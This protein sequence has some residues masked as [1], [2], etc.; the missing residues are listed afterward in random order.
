MKKFNFKDISV[1]DYQNLVKIFHEES[2]RAASVLAGSYI[3]HMLG[4]FIRSYMVEDIKEDKLF[5][6]FGPFATFSRRINTAYA[7]GLISKND[8]DDL[9]KIQEIRN[10]FAHFPKNIT[11]DTQ[12]IKD[13]CVNLEIS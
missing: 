10:Q 2:D 4:K 11:F 9:K 12:E 3:E 8:R 7:F 13:L 6:G 1:L 5:A